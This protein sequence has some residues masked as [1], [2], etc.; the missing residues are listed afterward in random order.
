MLM[1]LEAA[2]ARRLEFGHK[3]K[4]VLDARDAKAHITLLAVV[5]AEMM[6]VNRV[7]GP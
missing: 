3:S 5:P 1:E 2:A 7:H 4:L 6:V